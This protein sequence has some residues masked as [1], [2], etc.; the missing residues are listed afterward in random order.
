VVSVGE[1]E[2]VPSPRLATGGDGNGG[3]APPALLT[4]SRQPGGPVQ[5]VVSPLHLVQKGESTA[6]L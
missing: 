4:L 1:V 5:Q 3:A 6:R 2:L